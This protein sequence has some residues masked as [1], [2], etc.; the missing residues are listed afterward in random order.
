MRVVIVR[1]KQQWVEVF[2]SIGVR[3]DFILS[4]DTLDTESICIDL[5]DG[6]WDVI[7]Y[8]KFWQAEILTFEEWKAEWKTNV[9][10]YEDWK[11]R[12]EPFK[13]L[14]AFAK[15]IHEGNVKRGFYDKKV[16]L[17]TALALIHSEVS[18]A[19]EAHRKNHHGNLEY[20][21]TRV[22][23]VKDSFQGTDE[24]FKKVYKKL[25]ETYLK[26]CVGGEMAGTLIRLL[27][28]CAYFGIDIDKYVKYE[29]QYNATRPY[30]HGKKY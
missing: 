28:A 15:E 7:E 17:P 4:N 1:N 20:F 2:K 9:I 3:C 25:Y 18:E 24:E 21:E 19:L 11:K 30:K 5:R 26:D 6:T 12:N 8:F 23:E 16:E 22:K 14:N 29:L 10:A 27:D 13:G